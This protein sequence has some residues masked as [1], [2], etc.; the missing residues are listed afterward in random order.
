MGRELRVKKDREAKT[1]K[2]GGFS[3][4][5]FLGVWE[6][7]GSL[8]RTIY[9]KRVESEERKR[10]KELHAFVALLFTLVHGDSVN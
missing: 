10:E 6:L 7:K 4:W 2:Y 8:F 9:G 1:K 3:R 5:L